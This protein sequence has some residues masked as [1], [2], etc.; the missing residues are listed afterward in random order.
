MVQVQV[1]VPE[2]QSGCRNVEAVTDGQAVMA[3]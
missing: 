3:S 1:Q 2:I